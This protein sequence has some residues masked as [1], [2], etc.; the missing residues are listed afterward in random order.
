MANPH[1][2]L[3]VVVNGT[4]VTLD[5]NPNAVLQS[6]LAKALHESGN[7][8]QPPDAWEFRDKDG[9]LLDPHKKISEYAGVQLFLNLK[10][11]VGG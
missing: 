9:H 11:G 1:E 6:V 3:V 4:P 5:V 10:A 8:G 2:S 7:T